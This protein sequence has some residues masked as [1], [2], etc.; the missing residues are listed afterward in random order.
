MYNYTNMLYLIHRISQTTRWAMVK[1]DIKHLLWFFSMCVRCAA[2]KGWYCATVREI[3]IVQI[4]LI[5]DQDRSYVCG[6][7]GPKSEGQMTSTP[8]RRRTP[9]QKSGNAK[10]GVARSG[11]WKRLPL[12]WERSQSRRKGV[13]R[14]IGHWGWVAM[15]QR[16]QLGH[17]GWELRTGHWIWWTEITAKHQ[18]DALG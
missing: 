8:Q 17:G 12:G 13:R 4:L 7:V 11:P 2:A 15:G 1:V 16:L 18:E 9:K 6:R 3:G 5:Q 14:D 10:H